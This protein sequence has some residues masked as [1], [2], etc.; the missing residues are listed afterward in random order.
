VLL[1]I[2]ESS[3]VDAMDLVALNTLRFAVAIPPMPPLVEVAATLFDFVPAVVAVTVTVTVQLLFTRIDAPLKLTL[4]VGIF[5]AVTVPP[6]QVVEAFG[7][8]AFCIPAG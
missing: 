3:D 2:V 1:P 8:A 6:V 7:T 4:G 5:V